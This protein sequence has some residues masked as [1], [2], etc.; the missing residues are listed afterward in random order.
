MKIILLKDVPNL[1]KAGEIREVKPG[2]ARNFLLPKNLAEVASGKTAQKI[3]AA[4]ALKALE[5][6]KKKQSLEEK[7]KT[8]DDKKIAFKVKVNAQ[9]R[10]Y[11][12]I[13]GREIA[14]ALNID[15][16]LVEVAPLKQIG[17][18]KLEI[19]AGINLAKVEIDISPEK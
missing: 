9:G 15:P 10:L 16:S 4:S 6:K 18:T 8:L 14:Q 13:T 11:R 5:V 7:V 17:K 12:A 1:G 3:L 19:K 2:Y